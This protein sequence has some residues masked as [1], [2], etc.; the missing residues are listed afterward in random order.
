MPTCSLVMRSSSVMSSTAGSKTLPLS[1]TAS[2][3]RP[4][5]NGLID[6]FCSRAASELPTFSPL[7]TRCTGLMISIC[8]RLI[9]VAI[10]S[11]WNHDVWPGSQP[12]GPGGT[13]T[14]TGAMAPT[15]AGAGTRLATIVSRV[16]IRS[17][18]VK[19]KPMLPC[20]YGSSSAMGWS[21][22]SARNSRKT[23][24]MVVF[25]PISTVALPRRAW[26]ICCIWREPTLSTPTTKH[27]G[28]SASSAFSLRP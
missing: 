5:V 15:R 9:L 26:R 14:S 11:A 3:T 13:M 17:A 21:G 23:L 20:T 22:F 2:T 19:T 6:S 28:E 18:S 1:Y 7:V 12:V 10:W 4:Y 27:L 16:W 8:P 24:R 25:L